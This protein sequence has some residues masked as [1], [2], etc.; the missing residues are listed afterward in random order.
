M[1]MGFWLCQK[2]C[3]CD[4]VKPGCCSTG[5]QTVFCGSRFCSPAE[6]RFAP[7]EG[8][9]AAAIWS[10]EKCKFFLLGLDNFILALD[11]KPLIGMLGSQ[12]IMTIPNPRLMR[13]KIKS[14]M[15]SFTPTY[16]PGKLHVVPDCFSRR[17]DSPNPP[18]PAVPLPTEAPNVG[19][20]YQ[21]NFGP[22]SWVSQPAFLAPLCLSPSEEDTAATEDTE[23]FLIG[24]LMSCLAALDKAPWQDPWQEELLLAPIQLQPQ[25]L[26]LPRLDAVAAACPLY[27]SLRSIVLAGAPEDK[28]MW[29]D[30][31][32]PYY[33]HRHALVV[34]GNVVLLHDRPI[35]PGPLRQEVLEHLHGAHG[36][37]T[38][39]YSRAIS[40]M[41]WPNMRDDI[42]KIRAACSS[43]NLNA[44][45]NP[46]QPPHPLQHPAYPFSDICADFFEHSSKSYLV[47]VDRYSNW[48]SLFQLTRDTSANVIK[49]LRDYFT[50]WGVAQS[51]STDGDK[52]FA[53]SIII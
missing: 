30:K 41:F 48:L 3:E 35:I 46:T 38:T 37:V 4:S 42:A 1:A 18:Q 11:H 14:L 45:S 53:P 43:C 29:P 16:I 28:S 52:V 33:Q 19:P 12:E 34:I 9:S 21:D 5:W 13:S 27:T 24:S 22:P 32:L 40:C 25:V 20:E 36:G 7:I 17:T 15:Y 23:H 26:S 6:S 47:V 39:M 49:V 31:I 10:M 2:H 8:E 44:P 51:I 50:T